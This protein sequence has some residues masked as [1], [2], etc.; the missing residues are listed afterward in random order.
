MR[1]EVL[2]LVHLADA[3]ACREMPGLVASRP[4]L[5]PADIYSETAVPGGRAALD[6]GV[7]TPFSCTAGSDCCDAMWIEKVHH[8]ENVLPEMRHSGLHYFPLIFSSYGRI[9]CESLATL[10]KIAATAARRMG[11]VNSD[12]LLHRTLENVG[13]ALVRRCVAMYSACV[14]PLSAEALDLVLG[15]GFAEE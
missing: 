13:V 10:S 3:S 4:L 11:V 2:N 8:Y 9:H 7:A 12:C 6:I 14:P 1:D 5:R 15:D